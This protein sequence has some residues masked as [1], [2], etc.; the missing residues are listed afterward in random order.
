M[1]TLQEALDIWNKE[2]D[3]S[4]KIK[5]CSQLSKEMEHQDSRTFLTSIGKEYMR[6]LA[7]ENTLLKEDEVYEKGF[8]VMEQDIFYRY[9]QHSTSILIEYFSDKDIIFLLSYRNNYYEVYNL[10]RKQTTKFHNQSYFGLHFN[11]F[12]TA[13]RKV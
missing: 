8:G 13:V 10:N 2:Q 9:Q 6:L 11:E 1:K 3:K 12:F 7:T 4:K 5:L